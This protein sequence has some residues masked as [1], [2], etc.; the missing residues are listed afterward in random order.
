MNAKR[1]IGIYGLALAMVLGVASPYAAAAKKRQP[2]PQVA[3]TP[4]GEKLLQ[5]YTDL[6]SDLRTEISDALP[7]VSPQKKAAYE[8]AR[9]AEI[10][11]DEALQAAHKAFGEIGRGRALV[12]HAKGKWIGGAEKGIAQTKQK[13]NKATSG[14]ER[15]KLQEELA[16]W[17]K[18]L[19]DGQ[20]ALK[21]RQAILDKALK[22]EPRLTRELEEAKAALATAQAN[23]L[24]AVKALGL[25]SVLAS[26][27]LDPALA[28]FVI[29][30]EATPRGLAK[31]AQQG[32]KQEKLIE[33]L[34][35]NDELMLQIATGDGASGGKI[36]RAMAIYS[37]IQEASPK[38]ATGTLQRLALAISLEH[39]EPIGQRSATAKT[40]APQHVDPVNRYLSYER[41]LLNHELDPG[42]KDLSVWDL[43]MVVDGEEPD[44]IAA[45]GRE[46]LRNYRP[47][48][49]TTDDY[50]WRYVALV[51]TDVRYGSQDN[52][53]DE[54]ELQ[55]FQNILKNGGVCGR[56][57]FVGR[58]IL[59]AFGVP[60]TAR[61]QRGHAA[62]VHWTPDGWVVCLGAG[63]GSGWTKG[64]YNR[65]LDFLANTQAREHPKAFMK[66]KRAQWIGD[67]MDEPRV[68]G[69]LSGKP[70]L[71]YG[72]SLYTQR[73]IIEETKAQALAAV[74]EE[75][76][77]ANESDVKYAIEFAEVTEADRKVSVDANGVI[78]IPAAATSKPT[79]SS[80]KIIFMPSSLGGL[81]MHYSRNGGEQEF[82]YTF[83]APKAGKYTLT[84]RIVTPSW[85]Q[86]LLA[87]ANGAARVDIALPH[88]VGMWDSTKPVQIELVKG[89]NVLNFT[90]K[91]DG[92]AKGFSIR[93]FTLTPMN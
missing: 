77:E 55:F 64:R 59:R 46:M 89:K 42:F 65:D 56:R 1:T 5:R 40:D 43:R 28:K 16:K 3:L 50:R 73:A 93:D 24:K 35:A 10:K 2:A 78:T 49:I 4:L 54:P 11:A 12:G 31:F 8:A 86:H 60:T 14:A 15:A 80:G 90:H 67:T 32:K 13:L 30:Y 83:N 69:L 26:D 23:T 71:W 76:G 63:W 6:L 29:M 52:K 17:E 33:D 18:N 19:A 45:W 38:A 21:Q 72:V 44:E 66:V 48:H 39:A 68:F 75:L 88:T 22:D 81:Q 62:L 84:A 53:Y 37:A 82:E 25:D 47:D 7:A 20:A 70:D 74:G 87:S 36:G 58:F 57:A 27:K 9:A 79:Q 34:L 41:A 92:Q 85:Q 91:S 61:P 51:R